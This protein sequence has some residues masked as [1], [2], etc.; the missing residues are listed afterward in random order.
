MLRTAVRN[1]GVNSMLPKKPRSMPTLPW[2][3][4]ALTIEGAGL[5]RDIFLLLI[6]V[7]RQAPNHMIISAR[8]VRFVAMRT[9][10]DLSLAD[11]MAAAISNKIEGAEAEQAVEI[12]VAFSR[13]TRKVTAVDV[14]KETAVALHR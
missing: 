14:P 3:S 6:E 4:I 5:K 1:C 8:P 10:L 9:I 2:L 12:L 13:M 11:G 7:S